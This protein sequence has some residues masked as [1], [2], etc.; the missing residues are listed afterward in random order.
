[1]VP[2]TDGAAE[3]PPQPEASV[4]APEMAPDETGSSRA[5]DERELRSARLD[6]RL[7][8]ATWVVVVAIVGLAAWFGYSV[9]LQ[10]R[11]ERAASPAYAIID[12]AQAAVDKKPSDAALRV[13]LAKALGAAGLFDQANAELTQAF[14]IKK[15]FL[16]A[17][18]VMAEIALLRKDYG[19][20]ET[21]LK[22]ILDI[23]I[24]GD[25]SQ[26][27]NVN[28]RREFAY[29]SLGEIALV[30]K[31]Y[32]LAVNYL[33]AAIRIRRDA[34]DS[35]VRLAQAYEGLGADDQAA[36]QLAIA[37]A[38]DPNFPE[39]H[40]ESGLILL[41]GGK[42]A[43]AAWEFRRAI[44]SAP[45]ATEPRTALAKL[46]TFTEWFDTAKQAAAAG[47]LTKAVEAID[48]ARAIDPK[49]YDAAMLDGKL[50]EQ[51]GQAAGAVDAYKAALEAAPG[52]KAA[53]A[54]LARA[55][56]AADSA[57][58]KGTK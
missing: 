27:A 16:D 20:A 45:E 19:K 25:V 12:A 30:R 29:F 55:Q 18:Q 36:K 41:R 32:E 44:D 5:V 48:I 56:A 8:I 33:K 15:D 37:L 50:L 57:A 4:R 47:D 34:S 26:Y 40:Y 24:T 52:D 22:K 10:D 14:K 23:T 11:I 43:D 6:T 7:S 35:Y 51:S 53:K 31:N 28:E 49:N 58:K 42:R 2:L 39:A 54:G 21:A 13:Q 1:M 17:Y 46:G 38:F 9:W 3:V